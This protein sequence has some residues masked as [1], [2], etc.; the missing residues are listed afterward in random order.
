MKKIT[1]LVLAAVLSLSGLEALNAQGFKDKF[2]TAT[3]FTTFLDIA[4]LPSSNY[5]NSAY[6]NSSNQL[7]GSYTASA[8]L[9]YSLF[10]YGVKLRYNLVD[11]SDDASLSIHV[12]PAL[13]IS[14]SSDNSGSSQ[15]N[16]GSF[17]FP[18]MIGFNTGNISTYKTS[19]NKGFGIAIG[20][21]YFNGGLIKVSDDDK[22]SYTDM[23]TQQ[24]V[25]IENEK[26]KTGKWMAPAMELCYRYWTKSNKAR[27]ISFFASFG[28]K[29]DLETNSS[30]QAIQQEGS[31]KGT[32][33]F[34]IMWSKYLNY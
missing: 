16:I 1:P 4:Q 34:R 29:T 12:Q 3:G 32:F 25:F 27:E 33:H 26:Q 17:S 21:E 15:S 5:L 28:G 10:T 13:G 9:S 31:S 30:F 2:F 19:K 8:P 14:L 24:T 11:F 18:V 6:Y 7:E 23:A 22:V 20:V